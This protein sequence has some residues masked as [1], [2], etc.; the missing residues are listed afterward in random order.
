[1]RHGRRAR[2]TFQAPRLSWSTSSSKAPADFACLPSERAAAPAPKAPSF[3]ILHVS[4]QSRAL[5]IARVWDIAQT[6]SMEIRPAVAGRIRGALSLR[7]VRVPVVD[8]AVCLGQSPTHLGPSSCVVVADVEAAGRTVRVGLLA[9]E[10]SRVT[11]ARLPRWAVLSVDELL[12][13]EELRVASDTGPD[14]VR[15]PV[16]ET[17]PGSSI[18]TDSG[19]PRTAPQ[20][21]AG[22]QSLSA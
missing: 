7:G 3:L 9:D 5:P 6:D 21:L 10:D 18:G 19:D 20:P 13:V 11:S 16:S 2:P 12:D 8:L 22:R 4:G 14:G 15:D 17:R 1:M